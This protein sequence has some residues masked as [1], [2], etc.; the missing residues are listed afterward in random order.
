MRFSVH[1]KLF[2][3]YWNAA[4]AAAA[5]GSLSLAC[6][7]CFSVPLSTRM[8]RGGC[9]QADTNPHDAAAADSWIRAQV[10]GRGDTE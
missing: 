2:S 6:G 3:S 9:D 1:K 5:L 4:A 7:K 8:R 10:G